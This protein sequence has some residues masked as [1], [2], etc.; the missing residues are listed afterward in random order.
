MIDD[1]TK[2]YIF[3]FVFENT[4]LEEKKIQTFVII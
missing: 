3:L 4:F 1:L 2:I